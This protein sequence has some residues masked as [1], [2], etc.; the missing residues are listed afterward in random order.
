MTSKQSLQN[1]ENEARE[2]ARES[3]SSLDPIGRLCDWLVLNDE[4]KAARDR[5]EAQGLADRALIDA[6]NGQR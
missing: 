5:G 4:E 6:V 2:S 3:G 1:I